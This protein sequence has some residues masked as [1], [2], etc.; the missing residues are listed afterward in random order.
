VALLAERTLGLCQYLLRR[1][2]AIVRLGDH[3]TRSGENETAEQ[4]YR[5]ALEVLNSGLRTYN[6][7]ADRSNIKRMS[8]IV[9]SRW[10]GVIGML[11]SRHESGIKRF[12]GACVKAVSTYKSNDARIVE[13]ALNSLNEWLSRVSTRPVTTNVDIERALVLKNRLIQLE[14]IVQTRIRISSD[15]REE[16]VKRA[17][18]A[19]Q[20]LDKVV[21]QSSA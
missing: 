1:V 18:D 8:E 19:M 15:K 3:F 11:S 2:E 14:N 13:A 4:T 9:I 17:G 21:A 10:L 20:R 16:L 12:L 6:Y 7:P 5:N